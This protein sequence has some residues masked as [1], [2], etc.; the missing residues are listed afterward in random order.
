MFLSHYWCLYLPLKLIKIYMFKK[1]GGTHTLICKHFFLFWFVV[2]RRWNILWK[3]VKWWVWVVH[4]FT[5]QKKF[6][7]ITVWLE[8]KLIC[9]LCSVAGLLNHIGQLLTL[10]QAHHYTPPSV[11]PSLLFSPF[12]NNSW[13]FLCDGC[14]PENKKHGLQFL[15]RVE[16]IEI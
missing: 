9:Y 13:V 1:G 2:S 3:E 4:N 11:S 7:F 6:N 14:C 12:K 16:E 15:I 5:F 10:Y 8:P